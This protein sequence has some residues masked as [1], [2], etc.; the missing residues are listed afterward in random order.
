MEQAINQG[1]VQTLPPLLS[2][3]DGTAETPALARGNAL[4]NPNT[5]EPLQEQ[6]AC[7]DAQVERALAASEAAFERAEWEN[8]PISERADILEAIAE[9]LSEPGLAAEIAYVDALTTG[10][11]LKVTEG[12]SV[13]APMTFR[14]AA[15]YLREGHLEKTLPG[16]VGDVESFRR[17]WGPSLLVSPWNGP[18]AIG[19]HKV[20]SAL[21]AGAP[22]IAK[23]SEWAPHSAV[24]IAEAINSMGLP[25][26]T[27]QLVCGSRQTGS[28]MV[29]DSRI[30]AISFTGG[31]AGGRAMTH[32]AANDFKRLQLELG[33]N[34]PLIVFPDADI[35]N[36]ARGIVFGMTN[37][38]AQWCRAL[39]RVIVHNS[40]KS[41][42]LDRVMALFAEVTLGNSLTRTSDMGPQI[43]H[44]Q[45][46]GI[47]GALE[48]LESCGGSLLSNTTMPDLPGYFIPPTLVDGCAPEHTIEEIF[49]PVASV[50]SFDTEAEALT[51]ANGT[52]YGLAAYV[53]SSNEE[54]AWAFSRKLRTG[55]VKI[56]GYNLLSLSPDAPRGAWGLSGLG[57]EG[58]GHTIEFFTG[59][60]VVGVAPPN[61]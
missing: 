57:E 55:G 7:S 54:A 58:T 59:A 52:D 11:V 22:C 17:P 56:N 8:T 3:I 28:T 43:N 48:R 61:N 35:E 51:L 25:R 19:C 13:V 46:Q 6:L 40:V 20:A 45:Y 21:A 34:N 12:M 44:G 33:G 49:G 53:Y 27:F 2:Y 36:A 38:N 30:R 41:A 47:L 39:G 26:G 31:T 37:L 24:L 42:L 23:P 10:A 5:L 14:A 4:L 60:R 9:K 50:H 15:Q 1:S 32:A 29:N 16:K 18:T